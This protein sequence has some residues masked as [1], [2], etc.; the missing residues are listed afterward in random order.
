MTCGEGD[1]RPRFFIG[2]QKLV[3]Q[4]RSIGRGFGGG[5]KEQGKTLIA[6]KYGIYYYYYYYFG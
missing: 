1:A 4:K 3:A 2:V 6:I 5:D